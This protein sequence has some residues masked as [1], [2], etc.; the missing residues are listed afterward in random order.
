MRWGGEGEEEEEEEDLVMR[1]GWME[2]IPHPKKLVI[3]ECRP[4]CSLQPSSRKSHS[5]RAS[6]TQAA[7]SHQPGSMRKTVT[8]KSAKVT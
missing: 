4:A 1:G 7:G 8:E 3:I 2:R 6:P 5:T